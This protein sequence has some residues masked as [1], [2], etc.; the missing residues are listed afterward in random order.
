MERLH[1]VRHRKLKDI[2]HNIR[3]KIV[4]FASEEKVDTI[5][6]G[7]CWKQEVNMGKKGNRAFVGISHAMLINMI[8]YKAE[9]CG[10][11]IITIEESYTSKA[12]FVAGDNIPVFG[13]TKGT[14]VFIGLYRTSKELLLMPI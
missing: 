13:E 6:I 11:R 7:K 12:S 2:F 14:P 10:I 3:R 1:Q 4:N 8:T 5:N 9:K